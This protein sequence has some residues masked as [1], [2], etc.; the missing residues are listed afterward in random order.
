MSAGGRESAIIYCRVSSKKQGVE[1][2]GLDSQELRCR[3]YAAANGYD[4]DA[5]FTD[6]VSGGGDFMKRPGM[7]AV[8]EHLKKNSAKG[9]VVIFDDL[10]RF[11]RDTVFHLKLR[12]AMAAY[13]ASVE[14]LNFK[15]E[16]TPEG[17]FVETVIAAQ[18]ELERLQNRRQVIQ[19][20]K[21]RLERGYWVFAA[22]VGYRYQHSKAEGKILVPD[23]TLAPI[24]REALEGYATGRFDIQAE[25]MRF[26]EAQA[27][28]P[29]NGEGRVRQQQVKEILTRPVYAGM[30]EAPNWDVPLRPGKHEALISYETYQRI[31]DR[32]AGKAKMPARRDTSAD[33]PLRGFIVCGD[34]DAPLTA[35]WSKGRHAVY[36]YYLCQTRSCVSYGKSIRREVLEGEFDALVRSLEP[37]P[38]LFRTARRMFETWWSHLFAVAEVRA[39]SL[40]KRLAE[41]ERQCEQFLDRIVEANAPSVIAAYEARIRKL[42]DEKITL[43]ERIANC[44]RPIRSFEDTYRTALDFLSNPWILWSSPRIEDKRAVLKLAFVERLAYVR[45]EGLRTANLALPFRVLGG[46]CGQ[47]Y[48]MVGPEGLEPPTRPL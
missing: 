23:E 37:T 35:C 1:G 14:C 29:K 9:Y 17:K 5:V 2:T 12:E 45:N 7:V 3:Q 38:L 47:N 16:D 18:G 28:F 4:V 33:F 48:E 36:P 6:D 21:A 30:V 27:D 22:P 25:V 44:R 39:T 46:I 13:N 32:L 15:F 11:A 42:E 20:M 43:T 26:L 40:K 34:C 8:L 31:Q 19:K 24:V 41:A 10:K